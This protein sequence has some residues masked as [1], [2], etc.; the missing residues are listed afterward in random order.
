MTDELVSSNLLY[1]Q[2]IVCPKNTNPK[3]NG[4]TPSK[5]INK[6]L[7]DFDKVDVIK[8]K[9]LEYSRYLRMV[10]QASMTPNPIKTSLCLKITS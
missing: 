6:L 4:I 10:I 3:K 7:Q 1:F 8:F 9:L 2:K 5:N